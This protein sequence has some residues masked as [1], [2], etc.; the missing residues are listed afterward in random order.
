ARQLPLVDSGRAA[1]E[2]SSMHILQSCLGGAVVACLAA[3][4]AC[5][6]PVPPDA[7]LH[8]MGERVTLGSLVYNVFEDQWKVQLGQTSEPRVPKDR[9]FLIHLSVVN[10]GSADLMIPALSLVDD[11]GQTYAELSN[12]EG[13]P[14]WTGYLRRVR[15][16]ET[17]QGNVVFDVPPKHYRLRVSDETAQTTRDIDIPLSFSSETPEIPAQQ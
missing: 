2:D 13:V 10:G 8:R 7:Q 12:G 5:T 16:A 9:F 4:A 1:D 17:L 11:S 14:D 15:P 3:G 6:R